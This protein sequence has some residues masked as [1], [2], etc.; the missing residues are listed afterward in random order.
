MTYVLK[1]HIFPEEEAKPTIMRVVHYL[2]AISESGYQF[3]G[4]VTKIDKFPII[5]FSYCSYIKKNPT[6]MFYVR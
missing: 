1:L 3:P 5:P 2:R 4:Y 6:K